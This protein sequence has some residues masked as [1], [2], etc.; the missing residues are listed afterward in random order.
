ME[1]RGCGG[2]GGGC[3][4]EERGSGAVGDVRGSVGVLV[5]VERRSV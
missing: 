3:E 1:V 5:G 2:G 4:G